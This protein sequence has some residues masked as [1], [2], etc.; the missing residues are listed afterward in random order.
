MPNQILFET[1]YSRGNI[2]TGLSAW[3]VYL[4]HKFKIEQE[5]WLPGKLHSKLNYKPRNRAFGAHNWNTHKSVPNKYVKQERCETNGTYLRKWLKT[6]FMIY[7]VVLNDREIGPLR[8][9]FNISLKVAPIDVYPK[10]DAKSV[11]NV[12]ENDHR[13]EFLLIWGPE[14]A[15]K[16]GLSGPYSPHIYKYLQWAC[17]EIL[18]WNQWELFVKVTKHKN[19]DLLW[20]PKWPIK[21]GLWGPYCTRLSK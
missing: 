13:P 4:K 21:L 20:G 18:I 5:V 1:P 14:V 12:W 9:I 7:F 11:E 15:R 6:S 2:E 19:F 3:N 17:E 8:P 10:T 16:L